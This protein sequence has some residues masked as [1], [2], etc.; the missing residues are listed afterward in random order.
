MVKET[1]QEIQKSVVLVCALSDIA[2]LDAGTKI[3]FQSLQLTPLPSRGRSFSVVPEQIF[4]YE[5]PCL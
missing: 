2:L 3:K 4:Q 5:H 1:K